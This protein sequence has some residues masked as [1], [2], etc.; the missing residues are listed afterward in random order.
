MTGDPSAL[1]GSDADS[2]SRG[3]MRRAR[4]ASAHQQATV[5]LVALERQHAPLEQELRAAFDRVARQSSFIL[6]EEVERFESEFAEFCS[7]R[8]CVGVASGTAALTIALIAAGIGP[9]NEVIVPAH[10]FISSA[11]AVVHAGATVIFCD[12]ERDTGLID[13]EAAADAVSANTAAILP[14]HLYGQACN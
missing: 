14:V 8:H 5:P 10:T 6:G 2:P 1:L 11:R 3:L 12:V 4:I 13:L 7:V 9:G